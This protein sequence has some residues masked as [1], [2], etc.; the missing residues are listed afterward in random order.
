M[1]VI[2]CIY[3]FQASLDDDDDD[4]QIICGFADDEPLVV[5]QE[6]KNKQTNK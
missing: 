2:E 5:S 4:S 1:N 6:N 3:F